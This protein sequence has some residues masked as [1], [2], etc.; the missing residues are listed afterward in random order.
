MTINLAELMQKARAVVALD[1][2]FKESREVKPLRECFQN[3]KALGVAEIDLRESASP[4]TILALCE[5][6]VAAK[7]VVEFHRGEEVFGTHNAVRYCRLIA[8]LGDHFQGTKPSEVK[9]E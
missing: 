3:A 1:Q 8:A 9:D 4:S 6:A 7:A 2:Q 5:I